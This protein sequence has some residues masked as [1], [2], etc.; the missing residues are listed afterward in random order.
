MHHYGLDP[1]HY[2]SAPALSWDGMLKMTGVKIELF[3]DM[4]MHDFTEKAK[5]GGIAMAGHRFLKA[6]NPK[7]GDSFNPSKLGMPKVRL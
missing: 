5:R 2:V 7:M 4:T 6:N 3:T 1:S